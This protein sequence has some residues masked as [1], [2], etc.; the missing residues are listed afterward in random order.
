MQQFHISLESNNSKVGKMV[1]TTSPRQTCP[2]ACPYKNNGCYGDNYGVNFMWNA[3]SRGTYST[4]LSWKN[5]ISKI[6]K[7][8]LGS[9]GRHNQVG[10][11]PG[12]NSVLDSRKSLELAKAFSSDKKQFFTFT[13]KE[14][15]RKNINTIK[16]C[17]D[18]GFT[19][20]IS[21][22]TPAKA[23][24]AVEAGL[25]AVLVKEKSEERYGTLPNGHPTMVCP[26]QWLKAKENKTLT[27][28]DCMLCYKNSPKRPVIVFWPHG[29]QEKKVIKQLR[30]LN[31]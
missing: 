6:K 27:C 26:N 12:E 25:P 14:L 2:D 28:K 5:F 10:D 18:L 29:S 17:N 31:S 11:M 23:V 15:T 3:L 22:D 30:I 4:G 21:C 9:K 24:M 8:P 19:I 16:R 1:V 13:H 7:L 20:N